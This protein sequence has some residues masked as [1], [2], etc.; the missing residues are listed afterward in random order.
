MFLT[1]EQLDQLDQLCEKIA[2]NP[3]R[4]GRVI[5]EIR[6][7]HPRNFLEEN[8]V[9]NADDLLIGYTTQ[10]HRVRLPQEEIAK[11][12]QKNRNREKTGAR[13]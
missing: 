13:D 9:Y 10:V 5:I 4:T 1:N 3:K 8:P 7:N 6:N 11:G 2:G 12:R